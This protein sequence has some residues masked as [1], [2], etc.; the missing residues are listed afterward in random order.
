[1]FWD[2]SSTKHGIMLK[3]GLIFLVIQRS[4]DFYSEF[5]VVLDYDKMNCDLVS[6]VFYNVFWSADSSYM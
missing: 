4:I 1:M 3:F 6:G 2:F 5:F